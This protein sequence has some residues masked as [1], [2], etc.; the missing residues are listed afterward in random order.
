GM[1]FDDKKPFIL[2]GSGLSEKDLFLENCMM[3]R[4][5]IR[6]LFLLDEKAV[7]KGND[8]EECSRFRKAGWAVYYLLST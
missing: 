5:N 1:V 2:P 8:F 3:V 6:G 7:K 4:R